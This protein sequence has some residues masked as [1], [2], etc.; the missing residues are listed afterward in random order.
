[1]AQRVLDGVAARLAAREL[2]DS[3][4]GIQSPRVV[5]HESH[6]A[7]AAYEAELSA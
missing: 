4:R 5:L 2:G 3:A 6:L 1:M 7:W